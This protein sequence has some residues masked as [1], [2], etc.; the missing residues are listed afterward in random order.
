MHAPRYLMIDRTREIRTAECAPLHSPPSGTRARAPP[1]AISAATRARR[2]WR[3]PPAAQTRRQ[4]PAPTAVRI[5]AR[6][7]RARQ[8]KRTATASATTWRPSRAPKPEDDA[9]HPASPRGRRTSLNDGQPRRP[10]RHRLG[11]CPLAPSR[12]RVRAHAPLTT[13]THPHLSSFYSAHVPRR[14]S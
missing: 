10:P 13:L 2:A 12:A 1:A 7:T 3:T 11:L 4:R 14:Q 5:E 6:H 8:S 9:A